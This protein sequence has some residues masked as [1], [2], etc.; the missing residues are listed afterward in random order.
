MELEALASCRYPHA[1]LKNDF[2]AVWFA[3]V[4]RRRCQARLN[5]DPVSAPG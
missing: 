5:D 2:V 4:E 3:A 1:I